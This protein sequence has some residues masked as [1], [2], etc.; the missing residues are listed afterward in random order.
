MRAQDAVKCSSLKL[1]SAAGFAKEFI[2]WGIIAERVFFIESVECGF[3]EEVSCRTTSIKKLNVGC[4]FYAGMFAQ[5]EFS[6]YSEF[7][8]ML[9]AYFEMD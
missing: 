7:W 8:L 2:M 1:L 6:L 5:I 4:L 3:L 9:I